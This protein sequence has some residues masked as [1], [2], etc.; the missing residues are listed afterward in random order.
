[1]E[2]FYCIF[3]LAGLGLLSF[4]LGR[5]LPKRIFAYDAVPFR[6]FGW[7]KGGRVY[8]KLGIRKWQNLVPDMSRILPGMMPAKQLVKHDLADLPLMLQETCVAEF[9][10]LF[11]AL[12]GF[13]CPLI[14][15]GWVSRVLAILYFVGNLPYILI[16]RYNRPRLRRLLRH[17]EERRGH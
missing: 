9:T 15:K 16:Q 10:H 3:Y 4:L 8:E 1:M 2:F 17:Q 6:P 5:L 12:A 14:W 13:V 11:L 7:E